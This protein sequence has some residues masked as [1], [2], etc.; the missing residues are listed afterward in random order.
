MKTTLELS[1]RRAET[2]R[3]QPDSDNSLPWQV[4][5]IGIVGVPSAIALFLVWSLV[6]G[7]AKDGGDQRKTLTEHATAAAAHAIE[8]KETGQRLERYLQLICVNT[9]KMDTEKAACIVR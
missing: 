9:A 2:D 6:V 1:D 5:A 3:R 4:R 7:Q 8:S